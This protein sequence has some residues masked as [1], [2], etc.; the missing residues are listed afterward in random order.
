MGVTTRQ[1]AGLRQ[2]IRGEQRVGGTMVYISTTGHSK[3][4]YNLV[5]VLATHPCEAIENL[6]LDGRQVFWNVGSDYNQTINGVNFGGDADGN[7]HTGPT[8]VQYNFGGL[9]FCAGF[10]GHQNSSR[11]DGGIFGG[12]AGP[13]T[14][15]DG[16]PAYAGYC[17]ALNAND[18]TWAPSVQ[19]GVGSAVADPVM[20]SGGGGGAPI[21]DG[22]IMNPGFGYASGSVAI[23]VVRAPGDTGVGD[24]IV[25][26]TASGGLLTSI[27]VTYGG[28]YTVTPSFIVAPP[29][30]T[31][32][33]P[34][35]AGC[36]YVYLKIEADSTT[37][38]QFPEIRFTM[39]GKSDI[40]DPRTATTGYTTNWALHIADVLA[41]PDPML[42]IGDGPISKLAHR[43]ARSAHCRG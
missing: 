42:G 34:Y 10:C 32:V 9:V 1:P 24:A 29:S 23:T 26:G 7:N 20:G 39:R 41:N 14:W 31:T 4:Q 17:T 33:T 13:A 6:Y 36:T 43:G 12:W 25:S 2:I 18:G 21:S 38:P 5:I 19:P 40:Y 30:S 28:L 11:T 35:L 3:R 8:G 15:N 22:T 37:F 16:D 27:G